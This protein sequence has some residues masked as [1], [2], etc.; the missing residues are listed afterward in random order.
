MTK[1][2][3]LVARLKAGIIEVCSQWL[4]IHR[5]TSQVTDSELSVVGWPLHIGSSGFAYN[6]RSR[7]N[8]LPRVR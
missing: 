8:H 6:S 7:S 3:G 4:C 2:F 1:N 5:L